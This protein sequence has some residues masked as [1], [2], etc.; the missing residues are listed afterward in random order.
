M[1]DRRRLAAALWFLLA[2]LVWNV[3]FDLG[4][5]VSASA[6]LHDRAVHLR[7]VG[8]RVEMASAMRAGV[9]DSARAAT[10]W[11]LP[12]AAVG[13]ALLA[14]RLRGVGRMSQR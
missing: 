12:A 6:Y 10:L 2:F 5:R 1:R 8:P 4:V 9:R 7:G 13:V 3:R 11:A 14:A